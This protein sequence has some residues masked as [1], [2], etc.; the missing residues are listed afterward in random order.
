MAYPRGELGVPTPTFVKYSPQD[1][2]KNVINLFKK[3]VVSHLREFEGFERRGKIFRGYVPRPPHTT[4]VLDTPL[5]IKNKFTLRE[6]GCT[7]SRAIC[8]IDN[9]ITYQS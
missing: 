1:L 9:S 5:V 8:L 4:S 3:G 6:R 2:S 7:I